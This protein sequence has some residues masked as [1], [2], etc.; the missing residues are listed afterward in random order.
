MPDSYRQAM[1]VLSPIESCIRA[2]SSAVE[3]PSTAHMNATVAISKMIDVS[4]PRMVASYRLPSH[5]HH[6]RTQG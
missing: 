1:C 2:R 6:E 4:S 3:C 5:R